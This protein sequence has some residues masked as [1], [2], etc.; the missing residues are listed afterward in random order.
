M[1]CLLN[2][3]E[4]PYDKVTWE[5]LCN[6]ALIII[7]DFKPPFSINEQCRKDCDQAMKELLEVCNF[8]PN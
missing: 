2:G 1:Y 8:E 7:D 3:K 6:P 4:I 5:E